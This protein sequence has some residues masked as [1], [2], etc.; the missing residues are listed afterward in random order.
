[1]KS[2]TYEIDFGTEFND[3]LNSEGGTETLN[4]VLQSAWNAYTYDNLD[5]F[6]IDV[7]NLTL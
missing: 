2:G 3:L 4:M 6:Y 5:V 7:E 1:M